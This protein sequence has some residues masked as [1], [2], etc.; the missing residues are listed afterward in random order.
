MSPVAL[1]LAR[2]LVEL[3]AWAWVPGMRVVHGDSA[4]LP[5][6]LVG[7]PSDSC[8][9]TPGDPRI[10]T[11]LTRSDLPDLDDPATGGA[12]LVALGHDAA[13]VRYSPSLHKQAAG[14]PWIADLFGS[15]INSS[16]TMHTSLGR[17]CAA[18]MIEL[19]SRQPCP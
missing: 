7:G 9:E 16:I 11:G 15:S 1:D 13:R 10:C 12:L 19:A 17:A 6:R 4:N 14:T 2:R 18:V 8:H 3:P 5:L